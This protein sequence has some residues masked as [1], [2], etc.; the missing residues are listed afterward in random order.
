MRW[1]IHGERAVYESPWLGL[2]LADVEL[3]DGQR[4]EPH[5]IRVPQHAA[6]AV[7]HDP[8]RGVLLIWRHRFIT[9]VWGWEIPAG[10]I[11]PGETPMAA[12]GREALE[13]TG[14]RPGA[15]QPLVKFRP[16]GGSSDQWFHIFLAEGATHVGE[17]TDLTEAQEIR[18]HRPHEVRDLIR[19]GQVTDGL[20]LTA[21]SYAFAFDE[22]A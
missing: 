17:P 20:S 4:F 2:H 9:D 21:L 19:S 7:V 11:E 18:W 13:E 12:A 5:V 22:L 16:S 3:P 8:D 6:G 15:L 14:W 10:R 1:T